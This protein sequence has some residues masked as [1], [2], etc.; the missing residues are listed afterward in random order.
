MKKITKLSLLSLLCLQGLF[1]D[2]YLD[3]NLN[4]SSQST[5]RPDALASNTKTVTINE[6]GIKIRVT[7]PKVVEANSYFNVTATMQNNIGYARMGGLTL[8][9][10]QMTNV[11]GKVLGNTFD[12]IDGYPPYSKIYNK[13]M[14]KAMRSEYYMIEGWEKKWYEGNKKK[15]RLKLRAP[16]AIGYFDVNVRGVLHFGKK[17]DRYEVTVP[18]YGKEDQ[19]GYRSK[20]F[21]IRIVE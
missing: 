20:R 3:R 18:K 11:A 7:Y 1:A 21:Q 13:Y 8:S 10:P 6:K 5:V 12:A 14:R 19:Q 15:M 4:S 9:F 17:N 2:G 16:N